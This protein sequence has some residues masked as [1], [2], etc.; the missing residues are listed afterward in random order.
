M[1]KQSAALIN[2]AR[3]DIVDW[4]A[5]CSA[6]HEKRI[7]ACYTDVTTPEP[8]PDEHEYWRVPNLFIT[9]HNTFMPMPDITNDVERLRENLRRYL[10]GQPPMG[11]V[12]RDRGY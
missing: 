7:G 8:L 10:G 12:Q 3:G 6:L 5:I 4:P 11:L 9:P 1:M 2:I